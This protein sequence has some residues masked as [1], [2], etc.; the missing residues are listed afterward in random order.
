MATTVKCT[1]CGEEKP[2]LAAPPFRP[3]TKL[4]DLGQEIQEK[5]CAGCYKSWIDMSVK[6]VN[7]TR[8]DTTDPRGQQLWLAQ[9]KSFLGLDTGGSGDPWARFLNQRVKVETTGGQ[10]ATA[11]LIGLDPDRLNFAEFDGGQT[12][13]GFTASAT[14]ARGSATIARDAVRTIEPAG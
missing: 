6:L 8:L 11:T 3:G 10:H 12:P 4:A 14:G 1:K 7:E 5:I 2:A 13:A 9:M